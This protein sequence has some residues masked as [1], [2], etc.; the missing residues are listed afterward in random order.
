MIFHF[1]CCSVKR[2][3][4]TFFVSTFFF[5]LGSD[6][7]L[8]AHTGWFVLVWRIPK[9]VR[10]TQGLLDSTVFLSVCLFTCLSVCQW[11]GC[12]FLFS[13]CAKNQTFKT[14][15]SFQIFRPARGIYCRVCGS[16]VV[17]FFWFCFKDRISVIVCCFCE[18]LLSLW[19]LFNKHLILGV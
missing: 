2:S 1:A 18:L 16:F 6:Y 4:C 15:K 3:I 11:V 12:L 9:P 17:C 7:Q 10:V 19:I 5:S 14:Q 8:D 13:I